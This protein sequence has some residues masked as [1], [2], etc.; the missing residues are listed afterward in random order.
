MLYI[1]TDKTGIPTPVCTKATS[2]QLQS[3]RFSATPQRT[4][5]DVLADSPN[6]TFRYKA[7]LD[8]AT[9]ALAVRS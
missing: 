5:A 4:P 6:V 8:P 9:S 2:V 3:E 1:C 7:L